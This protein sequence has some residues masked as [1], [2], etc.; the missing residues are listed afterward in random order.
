MIDLLHG[1]GT[2]RRELPAKYIQFKRYDIDISKVPMLVYPTLH[3]QNGG[4][5]INEWAETSVPGLFSAGEVAGGVHGRNRL[6]GNSLLDVLVF[7]R[8][9]GLR[10]T[11]YASAHKGD[12]KLTLEHADRFN[13]EVKKAG[14][15][16][17]PIGPVVLPDYA[18]DHVRSR[19]W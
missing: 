2:V 4:I 7:G 10:A 3:Y 5:D 12:G 14:I 17:A 1:D 19:Q 11:E 9:S 13:A 16:D 8:R 15:K 18:P 6:M